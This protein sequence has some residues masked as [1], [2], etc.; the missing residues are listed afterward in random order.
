MQFYS[1]LKIIESNDIGLFV[2]LALVL[3]LSYSNHTHSLAHSPLDTH[4]RL[5]CLN[6]HNDEAMPNR[7]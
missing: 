1:L 7:N 2:F 3:F 5:K 6:S 4:I